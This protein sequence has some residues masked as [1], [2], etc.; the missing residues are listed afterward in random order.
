MRPDADDQGRRDF[1]F[2]QYRENRIARARRL[3]ERGEP[4]P[5]DFIHQLY[6]LGIDVEALEFT[7]G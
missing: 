7:Y 6:D 3:L 1:R 4:L 5:L 2:D